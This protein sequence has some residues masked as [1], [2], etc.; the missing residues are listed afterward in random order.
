MQ[1][2]LDS[3][4]VPFHEALH[5]DVICDDE[6]HIFALER[7]FCDI[8]N[9]IQIADGSLPRVKPFTRKTYW[10]NDLSELKAT[11]IDAFSI[12][13][14]VGKAQAGPIFEMKQKA[15]HS[16]KKGVK[17]AKREFDQEAC[18]RLYNDLAGKDSV[19]FWKACVTPKCSSKL[20]FHWTC[21]NW[22]CS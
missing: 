1:D 6:H 3:I 16:Y 21:S 2:A 13:N 18:N 22:Y 9:A 4:N 15:Q 20:T 10:N 7:Y 12:W 14:S 5:G 17:D 8:V 11:S 19:H